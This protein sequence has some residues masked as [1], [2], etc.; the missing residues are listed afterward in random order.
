MVVLTEVGHPWFAVVRILRVMFFPALLQEGTS[1]IELLQANGFAKS[2]LIGKDPDAG[3]VWGQEKGTTEDEMAGWHHRLNGHEF[4]GIPGVGDRQG[5]LACCDSWGRRVGHDWAT[6]LNWTERFCRWWTIK[7]LKM[8]VNATDHLCTGRWG[9]D[10]TSLAG[11]LI[12]VCRSS[13]GTL[14]SRRVCIHSLPRVA[15]PENLH[16]G[17]RVE[18]GWGSDCKKQTVVKVCAGQTNWLY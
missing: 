4:E 12:Q 10:C 18:S 2:W 8:L 7:E 15:S 17:T 3:R 1:L 16:E 5:G 11:G 14:P 13:D 6:E 9:P